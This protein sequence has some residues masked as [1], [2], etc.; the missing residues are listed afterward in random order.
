MDS[1]LSQEIT[2][3]KLRTIGASSEHAKYS[4]TDF[5]SILSQQKV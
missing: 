1:I 2:R 3:K 5:D 4:Q